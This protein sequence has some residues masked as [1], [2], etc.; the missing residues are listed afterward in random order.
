M[1]GGSTIMIPKL[2]LLSLDLR[3]ANFA[4]FL[5]HL[6]LFIYVIG[7]AHFLPLL[8]ETWPML[9]NY[10]P[11]PILNLVALLGIL[12]AHQI[13]TECSPRLQSCQVACLSCNRDLASHV[14]CNPRPPMSIEGDGSPSRMRFCL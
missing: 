1:D 3:N 11:K 13:L 6:A 14:P 12:F 9:P 10:I 7:H 2:D 8:L 4:S 5:V